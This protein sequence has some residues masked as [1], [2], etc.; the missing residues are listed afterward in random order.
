LGSQPGKNDWDALKQAFKNELGKK[1]T[2]NGAQ[3]DRK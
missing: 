2:A 3:D 1:L